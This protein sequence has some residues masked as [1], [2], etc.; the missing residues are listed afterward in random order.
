VSKRNSKSAEAPA[1]AKPLPVGDPYP[2]DAVF[3]DRYA[4]LSVADFLALPVAITALPE[5]VLP[6]YTWKFLV[7]NDKGAKR[8]LIGR[9]DPVYN[10]Q[11]KC[12]KCF[13]T[14]RELVVSDLED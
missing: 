10:S 2:Q 13:V 4:L 14:F 6:G 9:Y 7:C 11:G 8:W 3:D 1:N 5:D 12:C